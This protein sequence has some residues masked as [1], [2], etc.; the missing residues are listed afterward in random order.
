MLRPQRLLRAL[1]DSLWRC[2]A[3]EAPPPPALGLQAQPV[4]VSARADC[5]KVGR[6]VGLMYER[7][8]SAEMISAGGPAV[9][10]AMQAIGWV[11]AR[12]R[13]V[14]LLPSF[15]EEGPGPS[16]AGQQPAGGGKGAA[17]GGGD[18]LLLYGPGGSSPPMTLGSGSGG[19]QQPQW[20]QQQSM[21]SMPR[22]QQHGSGSSSGGG[23]GG[24]TCVFLKFSVVPCRT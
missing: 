13:S 14:M 5:S 24:E 4:R 11:Q 15:L 8:G 6:V 3:A 17:A 16:A 19:C 22:L 10:V 9:H 12:G 2:C 1:N 18:D 21:G 20:S 7:D 23:G